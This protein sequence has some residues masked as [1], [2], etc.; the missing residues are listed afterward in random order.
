MAR[1]DD[2]DGELDY[3]G[4]AAQDLVKKTMS[5]LSGENDFNTV[6]VHHQVNI[7]TYCRSYLIGPIIT[8]MMMITVVMILIETTMMR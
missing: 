7:S 3:W 5:Q 4:G 6:N 8:P 2:V 1:G